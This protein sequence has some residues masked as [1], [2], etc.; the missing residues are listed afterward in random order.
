[1]PELA[2]ALY[3]GITGGRSR[4]IDAKPLAARVAAIEKRAGS[5]SAAAKLIGVSPETLR[6]WLKGGQTPTG[7]NAAKLDAAGRRA[8]LSARREEQLRKQKALSTG[9]KNPRGKTIINRHRMVIKGTIRV[10]GDERDDRKIDVGEYLPAEVVGNVLDA[11]LSGDDARA[12]DLLTT[13][14]HEHYVAG[15]E[16]VQ[17]NTL[18]FE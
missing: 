2:D 1:M 8:V 13:G 9:K 3:K 15:M 7:K 6:R 4:A 17:V 11:W 14:I 16:L 18:K 5:R 10:S 12:V